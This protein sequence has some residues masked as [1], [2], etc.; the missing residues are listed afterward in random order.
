MIEVIKNTQ[1]EHRGVDEVRAN[2]YSLILLSYVDTMSGLDPWVERVHGELSPER[3]W[4]NTVV[5]DGLHY[6]LVPV[7]DVGSFPEYLQDMENTPALELRQRLLGEY[8]LRAIRRDPAS[9]LSVEEALKSPENY[10][11][12]LADR[13]R[14]LDDEPNSRAHQIERAAY[15]LIVN[16]DRMKS[17]VLEHLHYMWNVYLKKEWERRRPALEEFA[18]LQHGLNTTSFIPNIISCNMETAQELQT[19]IS[20]AREVRFCPSPHV[21]PYFGKMRRGSLVVIFYGEGSIRREKGGGI[22]QS[23]MTQMFQALGDESRMEIVS[24]LLRRGRLSQP[25]IMEACGFSAS[26]ASRQLK[27]LSALDLIEEQR[28]EG[29]KNMKCYQVNRDTFTALA[30]SIIHW[31]G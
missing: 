7:R 4:L 17:V 25:E 2:L 12:Y 26:G 23:Q 8:E 6:T 9:G 27:L 31:V 29:T 3:R 15:E 28:C 14:S 18:K 5:M 11:T 16:P 24:L 19:W 22:G 30:Q 10:L 21:G 20:Q 13:Y 1:S